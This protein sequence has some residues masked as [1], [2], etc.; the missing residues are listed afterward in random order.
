MASVSA[1]TREVSFSMQISRYNLH[2]SSNQFNMCSVCKGVPQ[3]INVECLGIKYAP[4]TRGAQVLGREKLVVLL[5]KR[6]EER[7]F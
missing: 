2:T 7:K 6:K 1:G 5:I 3:V 4:T